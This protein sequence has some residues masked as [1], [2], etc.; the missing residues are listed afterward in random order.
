[1]KKEVKDKMIRY[2]NLPTVKQANLYGK[3]RKKGFSIKISENL[4]KRPGL[5]KKVLSLRRR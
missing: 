3:L 4:M 5:A 1:M 2:K